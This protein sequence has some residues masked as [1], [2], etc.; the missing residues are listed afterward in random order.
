MVFVRHIV[1]WKPPIWTI[2]LS[3]IKFNSNEFMHSTVLLRI[4]KMTFMLVGGAV[5]AGM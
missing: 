1:M 5:I 2:M 3:K 4:A